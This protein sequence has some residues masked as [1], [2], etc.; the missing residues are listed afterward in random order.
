VCAATPLSCRALWG[1]IGVKRRSGL[2]AQSGL[3]SQVV[4]R[5]FALEPAL[6]QA[7]IGQGAVYVDGRRCADPGRKVAAGAKLTAVLE[8]RG[9][10]G[11]LE[12]AP[13]LVVLFEDADVLAVAKP[14]GLP[15]QPTPSGAGPNLLA[16][17]T[18]HLGKLAGLVHRLD[19][20]TTGVTV[21]GKSKAATSR[22]AAAFRQGR[23]AKTYLAVCGPEL[24]ERG[25]ID[26]PLSRDPS[27]P[28]RW[29][30][31]KRANGLAASSRFERRGVGEGF[32]LVEL[33]PQTGR[34]HQLRAHLASVGA[35]I[36]GDTLY[37]G[38]PVP[39]RPGAAPPSRCLLHALRLELDGQ[40]YEAPVPEDLQRYLDAVV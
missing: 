33:F 14:A 5:A 11:R 8:E 3:L 9:G 18:A 1:A 6:A 37:G 26:A 21:F 31:S 10:E 19:R 2:A 35:P 29:R 25:V 38:A 15:A 7:L 23:A 24:P 4:A 40:V 30:A 20:D 16:L 32:A 17:A 13:K 12:P 22:L 39:P 36:V 28:G 34:T 27:R